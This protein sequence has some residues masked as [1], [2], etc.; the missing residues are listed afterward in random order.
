[1]DAQTLKREGPGPDTKGEE[2]KR[3]GAQPGFRGKWGRGTQTK[4]IV[5]EVQGRLGLPVGGR[6][7]APLR[8]RLTNQEGGGPVSKKITQHITATI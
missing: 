5:L 2:E 8:F 1:M 4:L 7:L 6:K 3:R